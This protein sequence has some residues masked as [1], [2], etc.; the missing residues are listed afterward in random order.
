MQADSGVI[1]IAAE[2]KYT[3]RIPQVRAEIIRGLE[4][5]VKETAYS[6]EGTAK[7]LAPIDT[8]FL[9]NSITA[10]M[11]A[12]LVWYVDVGAEYGIHQEFG[13]RYVPAHPFLH[14]AVHREKPVFERRI[15]DVLRNAS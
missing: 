6:I 3:N 15:R 2:V 10:N 1:R 5:A 7:Q 9:R 8:G 13:T 14:P 11:F 12:P 4:N